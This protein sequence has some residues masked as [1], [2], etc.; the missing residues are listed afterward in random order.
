MPRNDGVALTERIAASVKADIL[1]KRIEAGTILTENDVARQFGCSRTPAREALRELLYEGYLA[2]TMGRGYV[3]ISPSVRDT[4]EGYQLRE[5]LEGEAANLAAKR[6]TPQDLENLEECLS[7]HEEDIQLVNRKFHMLIAEAA[8]NRKLRN[9]I[10]QLIDE[11]RRA[12][13]LDPGMWSTAYMAEH[14]TIFAALRNGDGP[15]AKEAM[16][17]HIRASRERVMQ[18]LR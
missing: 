3:V 5:I 2:L 18:G 8:G 15:A 1:A 17:Q 12:V 6:V 14:E 11:M 16:I 7:P 9:I 4:S 13:E 10:G